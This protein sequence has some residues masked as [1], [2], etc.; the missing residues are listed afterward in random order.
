MA[1]S[2]SCIADHVLLAAGIARL[3]LARKNSAC[4]LVDFYHIGFMSN[5]G[6]R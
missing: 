6:Y 2:R 4:K 1:A 5:F 3:K